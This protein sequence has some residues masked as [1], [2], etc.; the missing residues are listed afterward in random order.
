MS[1]DCSEFFVWFNLGTLFPV[2]LYFVALLHGHS[3]NGVFA[4]FPHGHDMTRTTHMGHGGDM[5]SCFT[6]A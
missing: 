4:M 6:L 5:V 3:K 2:W 1:F